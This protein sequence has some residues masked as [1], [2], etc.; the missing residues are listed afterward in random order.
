MTLALQAER[1]AQDVATTT[2]TTHEWWV[3]RLFEG[4]RNTDDP[5]AQA[6]LAEARE[7]RQQARAAYE[8]GDREAARELGHQ[9][10][11]K[12]LCAV[13]EVFPNA[14]ERTGA[15]VDQAL[16]RIETY[17]GDREAPRIR[18]IL[19]HV[20]ELRDQADALI[21]TDPVG[22]LALNLRAIQILHR[23]VSHVRDAHDHDRSADDEM[24]VVSF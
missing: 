1:M 7:L 13:V 19:A 15:A 24:H 3:H 14:P 8:A 2:R 4:L 12:V 10:F 17:L 22:A 5:E 16:E 23:L 20:H 9:S 21:A 18:A 6:C 11:L